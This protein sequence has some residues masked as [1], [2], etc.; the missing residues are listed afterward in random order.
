MS[1]STPSPIWPR[2]SS[3]KLTV[4]VRRPGS[5]MLK[6]ISC[7]RISAMAMR[8]SRFQSTPFM[9]RSRCESKMSTRGSPASA[10]RREVPTVYQRQ[11]PASPGNADYPVNDVTKHRPAPQYIAT[12]GGRP[13]ETP[14][15]LSLRPW[16]SG[17]IGRLKVVLRSEVRG[18]LDNRRADVNENELDTAKKYLVLQ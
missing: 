16:H 8:R 6:V 1:V 15:H 7:T 18:P 3:G 5:V 2:F 9:A 10:M 17:G 13:S 14:P 11:S 4:P 12:G